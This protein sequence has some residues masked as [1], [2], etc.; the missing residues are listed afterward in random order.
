MSLIPTGPVAGMEYG[1][2]AVGNGNYLGATA[3][4]GSPN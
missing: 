1:R 2:V 4:G 3:G